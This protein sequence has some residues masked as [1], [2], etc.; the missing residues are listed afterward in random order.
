MNEKKE[1]E[2]IYLFIIK[3]ALNRTWF[4]H[5]CNTQKVKEKMKL[6]H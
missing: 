3:S 5:A 4:E 1:K 6:D 2:I